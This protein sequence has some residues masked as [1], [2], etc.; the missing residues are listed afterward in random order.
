MKV[1]I[2]YIFATRNHLFF[3]VSLVTPFSN[4]YF[5]FDNQLYE[6]EF[7]IR[8]N[9]FQGCATHFGSANKYVAKTFYNLC[10]CSKTTSC[11]NMRITSYTASEQ[12]LVLSGL[13]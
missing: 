2:L 13:Q 1:I 8:C 10:L 12:L 6:I 3:N 7:C 5:F 9:L 4:S 11:Y